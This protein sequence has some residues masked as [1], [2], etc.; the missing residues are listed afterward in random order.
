M[1]RRL[2]AAV[3]L[4]T[5]L[6]GML[7][8]VALAECMSWPIKATERPQFGYAFTATVTEASSDVDHPTTY[9]A[10]YTWLY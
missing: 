6:A 5:L 2:V 1:A 7:S 3:A 9:E 10:N 4:A 8:P